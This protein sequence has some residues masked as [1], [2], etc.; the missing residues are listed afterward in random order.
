MRWFV[1]KLPAPCLVGQRNDASACAVVSGCV[2]VAV[3]H[4]QDLPIVPK[5]MCTTVAQRAG[6]IGLHP[7]RAAKQPSSGTSLTTILEATANTEVPARGL[8]SGGSLGAASGATACATVALV[9]YASE[10]QCRG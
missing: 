1:C 2:A 3:A 6:G 9:M 10:F 7:I 5:G 4:L 8:A